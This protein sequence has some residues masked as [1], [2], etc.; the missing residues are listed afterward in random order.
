MTSNWLLAFSSL[1]S[2]VILDCGVC[3]SIFDY[4]AQF[5]KLGDVGH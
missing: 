3:V 4:A 2:K 1:S 5:N